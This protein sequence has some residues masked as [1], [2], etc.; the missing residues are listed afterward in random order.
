MND[1]IEF[2]KKLGVNKKPYQHPSD[3]KHLKNLCVNEKNYKSYV[4]S[5]QY[6]KGST[7][8][9]TNLLPIPYVGNLKTAKIFIVLLNPGLNVIDYYSEDTLEYQCELI[10]NLYQEKLNTKYPFVFL[11]PKFLWYSG[12]RFWRNK[13]KHYII[14]TKKTTGKSYEDSLSFV[15][16]KI[17]ALELIPYHSINCNSNSVIKKLDSTAEMLRFINEYVIP[18][19]KINQCCLIITRATKLFDIDPN[20]KN[21][22]LFKANQSRAAHLSTKNSA[23][24]KK[25]SEF[26]GI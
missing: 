10:K 7:S 13:L 18:K 22:V 16:K 3:K 4:S 15:S 12:G 25:I 2:W 6:W 20:N 19:T 11:N 8:F 5:D 23:T 24:E 26:L 14:K 9:H 17:V 21:I 1:L